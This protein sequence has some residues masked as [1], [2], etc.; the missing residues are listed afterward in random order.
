[1]GPLG[2]TLGCHQNFD[3]FGATLGKHLSP[4]LKPNHS[5]GLFIR[6]YLDNY[7]VPHPPIPRLGIM[8]RFPTPP[9]IP[10]KMSLTESGIGIVPTPIFADP[11]CEHKGSDSRV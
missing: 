5:N 11:A 2:Q 1:M 6:N 4:P 9:P 7:Q 10:Q 3:I 8:I